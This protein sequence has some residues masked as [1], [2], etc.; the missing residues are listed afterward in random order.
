MVR[1]LWMVRPM[2]C[3][4]VGNI[5][6]SRFILYLNWSFEENMRA[7]MHT[8]NTKRLELHPQIPHLMACILQR[9]NG[10]RIDAVNWKMAIEYREYD[11]KALRYYTLKEGEVNRIRRIG[12]VAL[13][14]EL[15]PKLERGVFWNRRTSLARRR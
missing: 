15:S 14:V 12:V 3:I 10:S 8:T 6:I 13:Q 2:A 7:C 4:F 11:S 1:L 9:R 5:Y